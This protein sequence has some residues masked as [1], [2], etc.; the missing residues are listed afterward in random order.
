MEL[1]FDYTLTKYIDFAICTAVVIAAILWK[2][3]RWYLVGFGGVYLLA[4]L[5]FHYDFLP[6]DFSY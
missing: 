5:G 4:T 6:E 2:E 3:Q 1:V